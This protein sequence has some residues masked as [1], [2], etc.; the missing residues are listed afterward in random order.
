MCSLTDPFAFCFSQ[1]GQQ[2]LQ[3][4]WAIYIY[5]YLFE[6]KNYIY[7]TITGRLC[8]GHPSTL[9]MAYGY[10]YINNANL[11]M[12]IY[13][14]ITWRLCHG[15]P[16]ALIKVCGHMYE[17]LFPFVCWPKNKAKPR[18]KLFLGCLKRCSC[19]WLTA[20]LALW[21]C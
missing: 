20:S 11:Y 15:H 2:H 16:S 18:R 6:K 8:Q 1:K 3:V 10:I 7:C 21:N 17:L 5:I 4:L 14:I 13:G 9:I 19:Q 12:Y